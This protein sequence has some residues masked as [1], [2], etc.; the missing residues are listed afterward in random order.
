M[1]LIVHIDEIKDA[2]LELARDLPAAELDATLRAPPA[3][4]FGTHRDARLESRLERVND[5]DIVFRGRFQVE[6]EAECR[7]CL[8]PVPVSIPV[9]FTLDLVRQDGLDAA[10]RA[11]G[12]AA[13][14]DD[15]EGSLG[16]SFDPTEDGQ[17]PFTGKRVDVWPALREQLL[18]A[19]PMHAQCRDDCKGLCQVC[20]GNLNEETCSCEQSV[21]DPR[22]SAL[23]SVKLQG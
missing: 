1:E 15:G 19:L 5:I 16:A 7:R 14:E 4:G 6:A 8:V 10:I 11:G 17:V 12:G 20:G 3:T 23:R 18:L 22:W 21:P 9:D 2:G 13:G